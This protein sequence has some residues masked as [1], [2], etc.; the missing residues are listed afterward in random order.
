MRRRPLTLT[1]AVGA[2]SAAALVPLSLASATSL[3]HITSPTL[4]VISFDAD[5][6]Q[7]MPS[8]EA[9][10]VTWTPAPACEADNT[11]LPIQDDTLRDAHPDQEPTTDR[12]VDDEDPGDSDATSTTDL[13]TSGQGASSVPE[14]T[15]PP[16]TDTHEDT[17]HAPAH[18]AT[19]PISA[20]PDNGL[21]QAVIP[22]EDTTDEIG[23]QL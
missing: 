11:S 7:S 2:T 22:D 21:P 3:G 13:E 4:H 18:E 14:S 5:M 6:C 19:P 12:A 1:L 23:D 16:A 9:I 8:S 17:V 20:D 15:T 10:T